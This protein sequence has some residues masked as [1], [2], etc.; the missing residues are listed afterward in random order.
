MSILV[1]ITRK[2]LRSYVKKL[3]R[4]KRCATAAQK[5]QKPLEAYAISL[6][7]IRSLGS[8][9]KAQVR[10][11]SLVPNHSANGIKQTIAQ[12]AALILTMLIFKFNGSKER[13]QY[14][15]EKDVMWDPP[16]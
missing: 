3:R 7:A 13:R 16:L 9:V 8:A 15:G 14:C 10:Y 6:D 4:Q 1:D 12:T 2:L 5:S 11:A